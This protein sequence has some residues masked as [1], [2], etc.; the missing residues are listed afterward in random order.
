[1]KDRVGVWAEGP[2]DQHKKLIYVSREY[3]LIHRVRKFENIRNAR[4]SVLNLW[5]KLYR[6]GLPISLITAYI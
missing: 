4:Q 5:L 2:T 3:I 1:M 6:L